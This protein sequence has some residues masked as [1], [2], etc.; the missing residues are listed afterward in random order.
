MV[1]EIQVKLLLFGDRSDKLLKYGRDQEKKEG[2]T[3]LS[4]L[5]FFILMNVYLYII[6]RNSKSNIWL[7][8]LK[9]C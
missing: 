8:T 2:E 7:I 3:K 9:I 5:E 6:G 4:E 1:S